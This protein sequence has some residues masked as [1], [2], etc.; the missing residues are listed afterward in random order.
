VVWYAASAQLKRAYCRNKRCRL[1]FDLPVS[2][3]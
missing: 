2:I 3:L 1:Q